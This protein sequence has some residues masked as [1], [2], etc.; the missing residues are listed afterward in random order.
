MQQHNRILALAAIAAREWAV[1]LSWFINLFSSFRN[2]VASTIKSKNR[3]LDFYELKC[4]PYSEISLK[5]ARICGMKT[6][7]ENNN[8]CENS[9]YLKME[10]LFQA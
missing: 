9:H 7:L 5:R 4:I 3:H 6:W 8:L 2:F 10:P 1:L